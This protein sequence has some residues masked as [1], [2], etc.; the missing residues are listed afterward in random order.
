[1]R[2]G[3]ATDGLPGRGTFSVKRP[4]EA[5]L[6]RREPPPVLAG[7]QRRAGKHKRR[8]A[9][10]QTSFPWPFV[11]SWKCFF[12]EGRPWLPPPHIWALEPLRQHKL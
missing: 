3:V 8:L 7:A 2:G 1:M 11:L 4:R 10:L 9:L 12:P 5:R 6:Q